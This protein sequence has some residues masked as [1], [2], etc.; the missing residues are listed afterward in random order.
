[1][2]V[3]EHRKL[4]ESSKINIRFCLVVTS[5]AVFKRFREDLITPLVRR[6][7]TSFG[8][9]LTLNEVIP[10]DA[11]LISDTLERCFEVCDIVIVSGGT[12]ISKRD[13]SADVVTSY[14]DKVIPGFGELFRYLTY[15]EFGSAAILSR[16]YAC[17]AKNGSTIVF[18][19]PGSPQA[20]ELALTKL[21]LPEVK[22]MVGELRKE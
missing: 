7:L 14:C 21:I 19:T 15:L 13:L 3:E 4:W 11:N 22:H 20:V 1:M 2:P 18:L 8:Y 12:G 16:S 5:D 17:V 9:E 6:L 10:N